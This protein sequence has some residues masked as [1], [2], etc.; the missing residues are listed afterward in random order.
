MFALA[1]TDSS[2]RVASMV[3]A[4]TAYTNARSGTP[5]RRRYF[6]RW[7][8]FLFMFACATLHEMAHM[9]VGY[10]SLDSQEHTPPR[11]SYLDYGGHV[12]NEE[13]VPIQVGESGRWLEANL[14]GGSIEYY[15]D[16]NQGPDQVTETIQAIV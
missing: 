4:H 2:Q 14:Y 13:G 1:K 8:N 11:V 5:E 12:I 6:D 9:F 10:L 16:S 7:Q 3:A 15:R